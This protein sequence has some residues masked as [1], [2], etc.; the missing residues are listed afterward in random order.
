MFIILY[1]YL[2]IKIIIKSFI[3]GREF[4]SKIFYINKSYEMTKFRFH[5]FPWANTFFI[6]WAIILRFGTRERFSNFTVIVLSINGILLSIFFILNL[7]Y[8]VNHKKIKS[9]T[10]F[11]D[12]NMTKLEEMILYIILIYLSYTKHKSKLKNSQYVDKLEINLGKR[13]GTPEIKEFVKRAI[14]NVLINIRIHEKQNYHKVF[15]KFRKKLKNLLKKES[16]NGLINDNDLNDIRVTF[17]EILNPLKEIGIQEK[18]L[19]SIFESIKSKSIADDEG[20]K[21]NRKIIELLYNY[22]DQFF[23]YFHKTFKSI[24]NQIK[25]NRLR[26]VLFCT[27]PLLAVI[28]FLFMF[29]KNR[30]LESVKS[31]KKQNNQ[32]KRTNVSLI[33]ALWDGDK[34]QIIELISSGANVNQID[35]SGLTPLILASAQGRFEIV[36]SLISHGADIN[37]TDH[38][39]LMAI[40]Y[41]TNEKHNDI[42]KLLLEQ[43]DTKYFRNSVLNKDYSRPEFYFSLYLL[44]KRIL[45]KIDNNSLEIASESFYQGQREF[46]LKNNL[47]AIS[48]FQ[49]ALSFMVHPDIYYAYGNSLMSLDRYHDAIKAYNLSN[50]LN[51]K[52]K[53]LVLYNIARAYSLLKSYSEAHEYLEKAIKAGY[54][55]FSQIKT[56]PDLAY[57]RSIKDFETMLGIYILENI[58]NIDNID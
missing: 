25:K 56:D 38:D 23:K 58:D 33:E 5:L 26:W 28:I 13:F 7:V 1:I 4:S 29:P 8:F 31:I 45:E 10:P 11:L 16:R 15:V 14:N 43:E 34:T 2:K 19:I 36:E 22:F 52:R 3:T 27:V 51:Y 57:L 40:D 39:G 17:M 49:K 21:N 24:S 6:G 48:N 44:R 41:A 54:S 53:E 20:I 42:E 12:R 50:L 47:K 37:A 35:K 32:I 30:D 46:D 9:Y 55:A 18:D